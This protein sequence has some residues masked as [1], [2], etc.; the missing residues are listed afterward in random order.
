MSE[1]SNLTL[2]WKVTENF[3]PEYWLNYGAKPGSQS[4]EHL[5]EVSSASTGAH[6]VVI[7]QSGSGK[8]FFLGRLI[9]EISLQTKARCL[10]M[11][12]NGDFT[13]IYDVKEKE[14]W[15]TASYDR[16]LGSVLG[17]PHER[18][19]EEFLAKW[20]AVPISVK[21]RLIPTKPEQQVPEHLEPESSKPEQAK[22]ELEKPEQPEPKHHELLTFSW[23]SLSMDLLAE[24]I[25][26]I[27]RGEL[28]HC[29]DFVRTVALLTNSKTSR[30]K[31]RNLIDHAETLMRLGRRLSQEDFGSIL[32]SEFSGG[33]RFFDLL[34]RVFGR[35]SA[36]D[37]LRRA[38]EYISDSVVRFYFGK[39]RAY[40]AAGILQDSGTEKPAS[41]IEQ[42]LSV[43]DLPSLPDRKTRQLAIN[44][45]V[46]TEWE[47]ARRAWS[48]ALKEPSENDMRTPVFVIVEE[49]HNVIPAEPRDD[50]D[51]ALRDQFRTIAAE[52]RKYGLFLILVSQRP[53]KLDPFVVSECENKVLMR[54]GSKT[55]LDRTR[56]LLGLEDVPDEDLKECLKFKIGRAML[57]G[58]WASH[59]PMRLYCAARRTAEGG[60]NLRE[61]H[62]AVPASSDVGPAKP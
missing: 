30:T 55:V 11:D 37:R 16:R 3:E 35:E 39:A 6:T 2:G 46:T 1:A 45:L 38:P 21:T 43:V 54:L 56:T 18:S 58:R 62:W 10:I 52:G 25:E 22:P 14:L 19:R 9:E 13:Q 48:L 50:A 40:Q 23:P 31:K 20:S 60:R 7:A 8:S 5:V 32:E 33:S 44:A 51:T 41:A 53:D 17:L 47:N 29:H 57:F 12:P 42:R 59:H 34:T 49:A 61:Q 24:E 36:L 26:P 28:T 15:E 27:L 4:N